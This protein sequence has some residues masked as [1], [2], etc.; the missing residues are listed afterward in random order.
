MVAAVTRN[1]VAQMPGS[2]SRSPEEI[3]TGKVVYG[4]GQGYY[5][6]VKHANGSIE[7]QLFRD[8]ALTDRAPFHLVQAPPERAAGTDYPVT[9]KQ[10]VE[11]G[12]RALDI[13]LTLND[14]DGHNVHWVSN[15]KDADGT[16]VST[17]VVI[18][19]G[20]M[21]G[22]QT[23]TESDGRR[24]TE[25]VSAIPLDPQTSTL[26]RL[27]RDLHVLAAVEPSD[28]P[29]SAVGTKGSSPTDA[30]GAASQQPGPV[31][32]LEGVWSGTYSVPWGS[33]SLTW[34]LARS[35]DKFT[36]MAVAGYD[37]GSTDDAGVVA[38]TVRD[39]AVSFSWISRRSCTATAIGNASVTGAT[40][41]GTYHTT[42]SGG[43]CDPLTPY[44]GTLTLTKR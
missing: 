21:S 34:T 24:R 41:S 3:D 8:Q 17:D 31:Q 39:G 14:E 30:N 37:D 4:L 7:V 22:T 20:V 5:R 27:L 28:I 6:T 19:N 36:G 16:R 2:D 18:E 1:A 33:G 42:L 40:I 11:S 43:D 44:D 35:S 9:L 26:M 29:F 23:E 12:D 32:D 25:Q 15:E 13:T 38:V 10:Q